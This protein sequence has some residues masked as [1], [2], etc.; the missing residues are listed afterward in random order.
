ME[1]EGNEL[2]KIWWDC[3]K[4]DMERLVLSREEKEN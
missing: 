2:R 4:E 1:S 3:V